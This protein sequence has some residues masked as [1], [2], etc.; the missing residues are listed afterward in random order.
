[1]NPSE[2]YNKNSILDDL[3][4]VIS[5]LEEQSEE[6][7]LGE[8]QK[9]LKE[10]LLHKLLFFATENR[11]GNLSRNVL[12][13]MPVAS[14]IRPGGTNY[15]GFSYNFAPSAE[16]FEREYLP[17]LSAFAHPGSPVYLLTVD[18]G[19]LQ[20]GIAQLLDV[21]NAKTIGK[22]TEHYGGLPRT[23][24]DAGIVMVVEPSVSINTYRIGDHKT[25]E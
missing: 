15:D 8:E 11:L 2:Q 10:S 5:P 25:H 23:F 12:Y 24:F 3:E 20:E 1:M 14:Q 6:D 19:K 18:T 16:A 21:F 7:L 13:V 9:E 4:S 22:I 17:K